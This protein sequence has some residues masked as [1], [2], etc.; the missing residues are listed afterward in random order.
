ML[1]YFS[2]ENRAKRRID[3]ACLDVKVMEDLH[4]F[5]R[6]SQVS[7][8]LQN[9]LPVESIKVATMARERI[10]QFTVFKFNTDWVLKTGARELRSEV[11]RVA[12]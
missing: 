8:R 10:A 3:R 1:N 9:A 12:T 5:P 2:R 7:R 11:F 4:T 6:R